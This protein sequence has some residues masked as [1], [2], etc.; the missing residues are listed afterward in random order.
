MFISRKI[1]ARAVQ[2]KRI[3]VKT[4]T[5]FM[6][7]LTALAIGFA[8]YFCCAAG[9]L[10]APDEI[11]VFT[12]EFEKKGE[13]GLTVHLNYAARARC[14]PD[15]AKEQAPC[16]VFRVMPEVVWGLSDTWNLGLHVP[17]SYSRN[18]HAA[19]LDGVKLRL[20]NL[21]LRESGGGDSFYFG[22]NYEVSAYSARITESRYN[23]E[24]RGILGANLGEWKLT[25]NP[26][27]N[28]ALSKNP[29]G[30]PLEFEVFTQVMRKLGKDFALGVEH[31]ASLGRLSRLRFDSASEQTTYLVTEFKTSKHFYFHIGVG[32]G[33]TAPSDKLVFKMLLGVPF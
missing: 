11:V 31:Y 20:Q 19:T 26:I 16:K 27:L 15:Y 3:T 30:R 13:A 29:N 22:A 33:W 10:A 4:A 2:S 23:A 14:T 1:M 25:L 12:D 7:F 6:S 32:H 5:G 24:L 18:T 9:A 28:T 21:H 8:G 17:L